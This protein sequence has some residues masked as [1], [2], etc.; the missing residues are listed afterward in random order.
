MQHSLSFFLLDI[1]NPL[2]VTFHRAI[3]VSLNPKT[4]LEDIIEL[5]FSRVLTSGG[6]PSAIKGLPLISELT[7]MGAG[8]IIVMPGGGITPDNLELI[9]KELPELREFHG[10]GSGAWKESR[11]E[12]RNDSLRMGLSPDY[13]YKETE[14]NTVLNLVNISKRIW[15]ENT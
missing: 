11:M 10:S 2:P 15:N 6:Q 9:L 13:A 5:G 1:A 7:S 4:S 8:R 12:H 14:A 3:D